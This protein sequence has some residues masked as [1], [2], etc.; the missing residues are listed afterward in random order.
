[1]NQTM[2]R[3]ALAALFTALIIVGAYLT[4]PLPVVPGVLV[5]FF[6]FVAGLIQGP[7]WAGASG[8]V[9]LGLG[10]LGLGV[11]A[12]GAGGAGQFAG[13]TGG[14][15]FGYVAALV[16]TG[17]LADRRNFH[18]LRSTLAVFG[19]LVALYA[20]GLPWLQYT[21]ASKFPD[22]YGDLG[23]AFLA[24]GPYLIGDLVKAAAAVL[25]VTLLRPLLKTYTPRKS[26]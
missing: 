23:K 25:L 3:V 5:P 2:L 17:A 20:L 14:F 1:M 11:F 12:G 4:I 24:M 7:L 18:P 26:R 19:G 9:Y 10:A 8:L 16:V 21:L 22:Q 15:L 6:L 13:P